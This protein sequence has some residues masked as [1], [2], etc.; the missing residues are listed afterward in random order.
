MGLPAAAAAVDFWRTSARTRRILA[1]AVRVTA[2]IL[3]SAFLGRVNQ[4]GQAI[5]TACVSLA[6]SK[7]EVTGGFYGAGR[8]RGR[9]RWDA[10]A[11]EEERWQLA[12]P[13]ANPAHLRT[14][15]GAVSRPN[16]TH[17]LPD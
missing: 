6:E 14:R 11:P 10:I 1:S 2:L 16:F 4:H 3:Q 5:C 9:C 17:G 15:P 12:P 8:S 7:R 13:L